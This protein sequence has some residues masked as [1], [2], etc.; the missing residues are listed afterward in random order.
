MNPPRGLLQSL[1]NLV[2]MP[3]IL[4]DDL[5]MDSMAIKVAF[6]NSHLGVEIFEDLTE[7]RV[8]RY[9]ERLISGYNPL[10]NHPLK[11]CPVKIFNIAISYMLFL[12][13]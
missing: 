4:T 5:C 9:L 2:L 1:N 10:N 11:F 8:I 7:F 13:I 3:F 6:R 12:H